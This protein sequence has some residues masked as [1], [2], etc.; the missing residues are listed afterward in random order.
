MG[1][2][3]QQSSSIG[4]NLLALDE[5]IEGPVVTYARSDFRDQDILGLC[6]K[7]R[8]LNKSYEYA[9]YSC[10]LG[11]KEVV[12]LATGSAAANLITA[13]YEL[14]QMEVSAL[15][16]MGATGGQNGEVN[17]VIVAKEA[18]CRDEVSKVLTKRKGQVRPNKQLVNKLEASLNRD[19]IPFENALVASVEAMYFF[20]KEVQKADADGAHYWDLETAS[21]LAFGKRYRIPAASILLSVAGKGNETIETYPP[22]ERLDFVESVLRSLTSSPL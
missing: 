5:R 17:K 3:N 19:K 20:E 18:L 1:N 9:V 10:F 22:I 2:K 15:V 7:H 6:E 21:V 13:L 14:S 16:R 11:G 12:L 8:L 4:Y